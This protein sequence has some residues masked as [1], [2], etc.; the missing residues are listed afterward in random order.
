[1]NY[2]NMEYEI[3]KFQKDYEEEWDNFIY[4]ESCNGTFLQTRE[5]LNYHEAGKYQDCSLLFYRKNKLAA[6]CPACEKNENGEKIFISH[7]GSTYG[8]IIVSTDILRIEKILTLLTEMEEYLQELGFIKCILKQTNS[9]MAAKSSELIEYCLYYKKYTEY[10]ELNLYIDFDKYNKENITENFAKLRK[11]L[12]KKC[13]NA[14]MNIRELSGEMDI[15]RFHD[16]LSDNLQKYSLKPYHT[17]ADLLDLKK[18]FPDNIEFWGCIYENKIV[19][20]SMVFIFEKGKCAHTQYL[21]ADS[22]YNEW[23]PM[24]YIYYKMIDIYKDRNM[25]YLSWGITTEHLGLEINNNLT[26]TKEEYGSSHNITRIYEKILEP[27]R[28]GIV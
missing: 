7:A 1:M 17:V 26:N 11:R 9:L 5:F 24:T 25:Q 8:G 15:Q 23:S 22:Q 6:V 28:K 20:V 21:A 2:Q 13:I 12:V 16:I 18:R 27:Y 14:E 10:K 3:V 4:Y 19:A